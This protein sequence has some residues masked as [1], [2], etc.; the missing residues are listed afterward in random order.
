MDTQLR[1]LLIEDDI[2]DV[3][4]LQ[5]TLDSMKVAYTMKVINDGDLVSGHL[6][7]GAALPDVIVMDLNL[8]K[9]HGKDILKQIKA[10]PQYSTIPVVVLTTSS[11]EL[12]RSYTLNLGAN[13]YLIKPTST[14]GLVKVAE[15]ILKQ[16]TGDNQSI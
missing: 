14:K 16:A 8:P 11:S 3:E 7:G 1:I 12:D 2:D 5:E 10:H 15:T 9:V 13:N 6:Q 4:L